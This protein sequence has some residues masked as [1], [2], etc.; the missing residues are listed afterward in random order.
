MD[1]SKLVEKL[2]AWI[3]EQVTAAD[4]QGV[5]LGLSGGID[6]AVLGALCKWSFPRSTLGVIMPCYSIP[7]DKEHALLVA[8]KFGIRTT[9]VVLD[10][11]FD[12]ML[13]TLPEYDIT[14]SA[15]RMAQSNLKVRLRML[16]LYYIANQLHFMV[17]GSSNRSEIAAGYFTKYGD[18][19]VDI[20]PLGS[21]VKQEIR[22]I[23]GFIGIPRP[24][25]DK[26]PSAGLW[27]GQTDEAEMGITYA[28]LDNYL[29][30]GQAEADVKAKIQA[31]MS[32]SEHKR[33]LPPIARFD[34]P[35]DRPGTKP[36]SRK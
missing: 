2:V 8:Q 7:E 5:V 36:R 4:C 24:I 20:M 10:D 28:D 13:Q 33:T 19:G 14:P 15:R 34:Q 16:T 18:G 12:S 31:M 11:M 32:A 3:K 1:T 17:A 29:L 26:P 23:A 35:E 25:I 6:S 9:E 22:D 21:F 27:E 30:A